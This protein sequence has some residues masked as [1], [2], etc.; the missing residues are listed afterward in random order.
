M[1]R[2][3]Q[4]FYSFEDAERADA[5]H[6]ASLSPQQRLD[7]LLDLIARYRRSL[8]KTAKRFKRVHR[9]VKLSRG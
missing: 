1:K 8:G 2:A 9:I 4:I 3:A 5:E 7:L 6:Y